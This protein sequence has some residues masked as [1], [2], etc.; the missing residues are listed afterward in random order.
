MESSGT[1]TLKTLAFA[2]LIIIIGLTAPLALLQAQ[3]NL[4]F[5]RVTASSPTVELYFSVGCDGNPAFNMSKQD[6]RIYENGVE[7]KNF[8][9]WCPDPTIPCAISVSLVFDAS[10]SMS[11][12]G[13]AGA[14]QAGH[15]FIDLM[16]GVID[17]AAVLWFTSA[18]TLYQQMTTIKPMLHSA[19]D[20]LPANGA[21]AVWDGCYMGL[22]ELI[23][24]GVNQCRAVILL[25][26]GGDNSSTRQPSEIIALANR[27]RIRVFTV[28]LGSSLNSVELELVAQLTGGKFYQ[29]PNAGQL[30][31]IY[32][33]IITIL[34][35]GFQECVI[36]YDRDCEDG[37]LRTVELQLKDFCGG[38]DTKTKTYRA[39]LDSSTFSSLTMEL[40]NAVGMSGTDITI[41]M[42]L[43]TPVNG[44]M[45]YPF[46]FE[47]KYDTSCVKLKSVATPSGSLLEGLPIAVTPTA[48]G[49]LIEV[50]GRKPL[51][52]TGTLMEFTFRTI[53][54]S[55]TSC[56]EI[57]GANPVFEQGCFVPVID[58]GEICIYPTLPSISCDIN[59]PDRLLWRR[60]IR[61]YSPNPFSIT[62]RVS[63]TGDA[64]ALNARYRILFDTSEVRL[65]SPLSD[66]QVLSPADIGPLTHTDVTWQLEPGL[67]LYADSIDI[68]IRSSFDNHPDVTC[69][70]KIFIPQTGAI[71]ECSL[72]APS[73]IA[74]SL[75]FR[76]VPM[77]F[78]LKVTVTN[79]G[80]TDTDSARATIV[81]PNDLELAAPDAPNQH[82]KIVMP[83]FGFPGDT[84]STSWMVTHPH[85]TVERR[86]TVIVWIVTRD[87]DSSKCEIDVIIPGLPAKDFTTTLQADGALRFCDGQ[88][89]ILDAGPGY[90]SYHWSNGRQT[91]GIQVET[92]GD[93]FCVV[94]HPDGRRGISDTIHV[95][96]LPT[97]APRL[98]VSGSIPFCEGN[99]VQLSVVGSFSQYQWSNAA[100][101]ASITARTAGSYYV[102]VRNA[103]SCW[104]YS[105]TVVVTTKPVPAKPII[106]RNGDVLTTGPEHA[107]QWYRDGVK[108]SVATNQ[109]LVLTGTGRYQVC[110]TNAEGCTVCSDDFIVTV[111]GIDD[112][113]PIAG[114]PAL[115]VYPEPASDA[116][117]ISLGRSE[118]QAVTLMLCDIL[119]RTEVIFKGMLAGDS[120]DFM[121]SLRDRKPGVYYLVAILSDAV[122]VKR[123]TKL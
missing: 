45:F 114:S 22:I 24:N 80:G 20:A 14:K 76:N 108:L 52:G 21:T 4:T 72:D 53:D 86:Y 33:E 65:V 82:T 120:P 1:F 19:V 79:N 92:S 18:V 62:T 44:E 10:G 96:V 88:S 113:Q 98:S 16:D 12:S 97:P 121:Y 8:T 110:V 3:P 67:R 75:F 101:S 38:T 106:Q 11:G 47:L 116:L 46:H 34:R 84:D 50:S 54:R 91:R 7:V 71:L 15:A 117:H 37:A 85:S 78:P 68:C 43:R 35:Q 111:L 99:S 48:A 23:N 122:L 103:D 40:D 41:P 109:F 28:G 107:Y 42:N 115:L 77:P 25:T 95:T 17:E 104:G 30:A 83:W 49:A 56:C 64:A 81:L 9:L 63:N 58:P 94:Q 39:P 89:V 69:C 66:T 31:A 123:V 112:E 36:T 74:D 93:Y 119:G 118:A 26:D 60:D 57:R 51:A 29:T 105:D 100:T 87:G 55:D 102:R 6:F 90:T 73:I 2:A 27:H 59:G 5:K 32:Q 13:N 61:D 70:M